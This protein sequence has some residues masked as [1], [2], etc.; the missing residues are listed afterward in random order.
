[1]LLLLSPIVPFGADFNLVKASYFVNSV[2]CESGAFRAGL[3]ALARH[4]LAFLY[5]VGLQPQSTL[6]YLV[7]HGPLIGKP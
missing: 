4:K 5:G 6:Y 2:F 7:G 1:M 3:T